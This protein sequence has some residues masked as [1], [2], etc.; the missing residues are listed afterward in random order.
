MEKFAWVVT[1]II[2]VAAV[3]ML[4]W[5]RDDYPALSWIVNIAVILV[6]AIFYSRVQHVKKVASRDVEK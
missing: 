6:A 5:Y 3:I 1:S 4:R 2:L